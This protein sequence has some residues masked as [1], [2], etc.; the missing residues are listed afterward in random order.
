MATAST[1]AAP[2]ASAEHVVLILAAGGS[3]R[4]GRAKQ[5]LCC[6]GETLIRRTV[7]LASATRPKRISVVVGAERE[8]ICRELADFDFTTISNDNWPSGLASSL[9]AGAPA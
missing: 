7:A 4:L 1:T 2:A 8:A 5:L 9:Q 6:Q 3:R